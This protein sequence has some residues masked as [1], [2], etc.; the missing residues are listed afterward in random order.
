LLI[1]VQAAI[2]A[3]DKPPIT[4]QAVDQ[5]VRNYANSLRR[6]VPDAY[7]PKLMNFVTPR[8]NIPKDDDHQ[9]MLFLLHV[10]EYMNG[11]PWYEV[12]P[13]LRTLDELQPE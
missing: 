11:S 5:A 4:R 13:V 6:E 9:T 8:D 12:N 1:L 10:L 2:G 3:V 7:W